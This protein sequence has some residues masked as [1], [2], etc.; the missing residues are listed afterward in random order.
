ML[1]CLILLAIAGLIQNSPVHPF[2]ESP[3]SNPEL[4]EGDI[5]GID[6]KV[7]YFKDFLNNHFKRFIQ[8]FF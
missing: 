7:S 6:P 8:L 3:M 2:T 4:F 1:R 5:A